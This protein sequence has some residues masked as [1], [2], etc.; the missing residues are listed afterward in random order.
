MHALGLAGRGG[1]FYLGMMHQGKSTK[2]EPQPVCHVK[3]GYPIHPAS[4]KGQKWPTAT[5]I[6]SAKHLPI[7]N[8]SDIYLWVFFTHG[9]GIGF[10]LLA[11]ES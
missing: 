11:F 7:Q 2:L 10:S 8:T 6:H 5:I 3:H 9:R 4:A 1:I